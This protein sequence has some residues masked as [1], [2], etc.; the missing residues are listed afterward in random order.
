MVPIRRWLRRFFEAVG[1]ASQSDI[2]ARYVERH[3]APA[4]LLGGEMLVVR[5]GR[6]LKAACLRCP[7]G[8]GEKIIL[9]LS[10]KHVPNWTI[11]MDSLARPTVYPSI[12]LLNQCRCHFWLEKGKILWCEDSRRMPFEGITVPNRHGYAFS[13]I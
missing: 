2:T 4:D 13:D 3:P 7:G 12:R 5:N 8:C 9:S 1:W 10:T 11:E 6:L